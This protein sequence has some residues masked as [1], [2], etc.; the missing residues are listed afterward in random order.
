MDSAAILRILDDASRA[1]AFPCLDNG[2]VYL[3]ATRLSLF[4]SPDDW[5]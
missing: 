1:F 5:L 4:R 3:A 2:Y